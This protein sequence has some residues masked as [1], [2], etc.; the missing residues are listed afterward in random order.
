MPETNGGT[1]VLDD[2]ERELVQLELGAVLPALTGERRQ[3][4]EQ[5]RDAVTSGS[6]PPQSVQLLESLLELALQTARA[7]QLYRAEGERILTHLFRRTPRG[8]ELTEL[9]DQVNR[10]L[11]ALAGRTLNRAHVG[12]RTVGHFTLTIETE[13]ATITLAVRPDSVNVESVAVGG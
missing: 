7:R 13:A 6:I 8:R 4:Y 10:A 11:V 1:I 5:L 12:M 9:L 2:E 3:R